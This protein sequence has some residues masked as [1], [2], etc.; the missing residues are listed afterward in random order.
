MAK[1]VADMHEE[2]L[3]SRDIKPQNVL[4]N[5]N[6]KGNYEASIADFGIAVPRDG[7]IQNAPVIAKVDLEQVVE[8]IVKHEEETQIS[9]GS[10]PFA[11]PEQAGG[12]I[13]PALD[14]FALGRTALYALGALNQLDLSKKAYTKD[15][16]GNISLTQPPERL[17][18][19]VPAPRRLVSILRQTQNLDPKKRP[20][21]EQIAEAAA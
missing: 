1:G 13:D 9:P 18:P 16:L 14:S 10:L 17:I 7:V 15:E 20:S 8:N 12:S 11:A 19:R 21:A 5:E 3:V 6:R 2:G 4:V